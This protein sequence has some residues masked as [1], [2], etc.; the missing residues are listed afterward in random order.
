MPGKNWVSR[1]IKRH[2]DKIKLSYLTPA[3]IACKR[4]DNLYQYK[5]FYELLKEKIEKYE[6]E[7]HNI[8]NMDEKGFLISVFNKSKRIYTKSEAV[9]GKLLGTSQDG[10]RKWIT[11]IVSIYTDG[12]S[13]PPG[14]IY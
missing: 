3:D 6:I 8:Y 13:L 7:V 5:L 10:N 1:F 9:W 11:V 2:K 12:I 14:L 4:A